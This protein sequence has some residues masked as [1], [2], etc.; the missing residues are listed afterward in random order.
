MFIQ[1]Y[2]NFSASLVRFPRF[3]SERSLDDS[4]NQFVSI[5]YVTQDIYSVTK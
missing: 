4:H 2:I 3:G 1:C 5:C